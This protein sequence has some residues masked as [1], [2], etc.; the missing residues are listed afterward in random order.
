MLAGVNVKNDDIENKK[1]TS[2][3]VCNKAGLS[4]LE[5]T[6]YVDATGD[7]DLSA[8]SGVEFTKGRDSDGACQPMTLNLKYEEC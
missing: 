1:I 2:I 8:W 5:S 6:I 3:S 7:A 4:S